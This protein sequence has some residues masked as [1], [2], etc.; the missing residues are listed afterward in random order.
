M[1]KIVLSIIVVIG[2]CGISFAQDYNSAIGLRL[3]LVN[4]VSYKAFLTETAAFE[5]FGSF[6]SQE[7]FTTFGV[8]A[9]YQIHGDIESVDRLRWYYGAGAGVA[10]YSYDSAYVGDGGG[11]GLAI[12]GYLGLE[13]T[14]QD[15][16]ISFSIDWI[17]TFVLGGV[18]GFDSDHG[19]LVVRYVLDAN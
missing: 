17:P 5:I 13:Y 9:G 19:A 6:R 12:N 16:P 3:G 15:A 10:A 7:L 4:S 14:L 18:S 1:K 2:F 11:I 8:N